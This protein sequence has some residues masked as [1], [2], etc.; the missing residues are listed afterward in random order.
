MCLILEI[1]GVIA[2]IFLA[3]VVIREIRLSRDDN[4]SIGE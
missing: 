2:L 3:H 1:I 4:N